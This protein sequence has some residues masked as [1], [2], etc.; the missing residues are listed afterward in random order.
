M[1]AKERTAFLTTMTNTQQP[2]RSSTLILLFCV[3]LLS[4]N[5]DAFVP[6]ARRSSPHFRL[7]TLPA[8][9][10]STTDEFQHLDDLKPPLINWRRESI[11]FG[12]SP[13]TQKNNNM[14]RLWR[15]LKQ[16]LPPVVTGANKPTAADE[17][18]IGGLF[19]MIFIRI[20]ILL[21]GVFYCVNV[22]TGHPLVMD[23]GYGLFEVNPIIVAGVLYLMLL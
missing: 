9:S 12:D 3:F 7:Q 6:V 8:D 11:L 19:N 2:L 15:D 16:S 21:S 23:I 22:A 1:N 10:D 17:N 20:P 18:P 13:A 4:K 5:V 14:L